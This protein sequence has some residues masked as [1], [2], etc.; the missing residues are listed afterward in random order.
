MEAEGERKM[1]DWEDCEREGGEVKAELLGR[2]MG[3]LVVLGEGSEE[4]VAVKR[5]GA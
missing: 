5:V 2:E 3:E 1:R 4:K